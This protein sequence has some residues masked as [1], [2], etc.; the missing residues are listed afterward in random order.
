MSSFLQAVLLLISAALYISGHREYV[1]LLVLSLALAWINV[2]YY[3]RGS[4]QMGIYSVMMQRM[5]VGDLLTFLCVYFVLLVGFSAAMVALMYDDK[6][7]QLQPR[8]ESLPSERSLE[9]G[10]VPCN[11]PAYSDFRFTI[12]ELFKFTIGMGNLEFTDDVQYREVFYILLISYIVLT[13]ILLLNM[14]IALMGNTVERISKENV[15]I[16]N[17]QKASTILDIERDLPQRLRRTLFSK[18][19]RMVYFKLHENDKSRRYLRVEEMN[20]R[21]WRSDLGVYPEDDPENQ[22]TDILGKQLKHH[23]PL[24]KI[25]LKH[26]KHHPKTLT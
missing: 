18:E 16:W 4:K 13:Y 3:S 25:R 14:L 20:W 2:L 19:S 9:V 15:D 17:L 24:E 22:I 26:W 5:I 12:L 1:G 8:N 21:Q 11:K 10:A 6:P 23:S 7:A